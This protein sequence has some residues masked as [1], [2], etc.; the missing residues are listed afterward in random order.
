MFINFHD[1]NDDNLLSKSEFFQ[2]VNDT[3]FMLVLEDA[4][5]IN[6]PK[7]YYWLHQ[8]KKKT[9]E[10]VLFPNKD[11]VLGEKDLLKMMKYFDSDRDEL[12]S[13][14]EIKAKFMQNRVEIARPFVNK[15]RKVFKRLDSLTYKDKT[16][17]KEG[18]EY[19][20]GGRDQLRAFNESD[21]F[22]QRWG[23]YLY[24]FDE[25]GKCSKKNDGC[26]PLYFF[27]CKKK[28]VYI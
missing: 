4:L 3:L 18:F 12:V 10:G 20:Y 16:V 23:G 26:I 6:N 17:V 24:N 9:I 13:R 27:V 21:G 25:V 28:Y 15:L 2:A 7:E 8:S 19:Y 1:K 11:D 22:C 5:K 14:K